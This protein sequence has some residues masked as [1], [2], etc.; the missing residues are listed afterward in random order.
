V[1]CCAMPQVES[2]SMIAAGAVV[3]AG[4]TVPSGELW[5]G[6]PARRVRA[7]KQEEKDHLEALPDRWGGERVFLGGGRADGWW[8]HIKTQGR[9]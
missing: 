9:A 7:L 6:N 5:A 8:L 1:L 4:T 3:E 2:G